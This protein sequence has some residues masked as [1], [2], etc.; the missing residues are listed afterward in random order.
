M[1]DSETKV[2]VNRSKSTPNILE[3]DEKLQ[4]R[5]NSEDHLKSVHNFAHAR[6]RQLKNSKQAPTRDNCVSSYRLRDESVVGEV[7]HKSAGFSFDTITDVNKVD[8]KL[9]FLAVVKQL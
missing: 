8:R 2:L 4:R 7:T 1:K 5:Y 9:E 6:N 3:I